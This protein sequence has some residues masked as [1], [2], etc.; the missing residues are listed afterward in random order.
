MVGKRESRTLGFAGGSVKSEKQRATRGGKNLGGCCEAVVERG[1][2]RVNLAKGKVKGAW[3][4][5]PALAEGACRASLYDFV[6][7]ERKFDI[8]AKAGAGLANRV[9]AN[10]SGI[11]V[12]V[13]HAF[14]RTTVAG[15]VAASTFERGLP[16]NC[17]RGAS[18]ER[19]L[20]RR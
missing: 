1:R 15:S 3:C 5:K 13:C 8:V 4:A 14:D 18:S 9:G 17:V 6:T 16:D 12:G 10:A 11:F 7:D 19:M 20:R 2:F